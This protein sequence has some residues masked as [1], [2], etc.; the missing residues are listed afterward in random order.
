MIKLSQKVLN[1]L[2]KVPPTKP[3]SKNVVDGAL[4]V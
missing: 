2:G 1:G 3:K 4:N